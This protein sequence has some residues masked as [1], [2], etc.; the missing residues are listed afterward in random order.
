MPRNE[1]PEGL[2]NFVKLIY[3]FI[4]SGAKANV[5]GPF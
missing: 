3:H 4:V 2:P 5:A 1:R